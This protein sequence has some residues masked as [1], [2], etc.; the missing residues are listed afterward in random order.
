[1]VCSDQAAQH[2]ADH[3]EAEEGG[4]GTGVALEVAG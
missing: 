1:M 3:G 2:D 4:G